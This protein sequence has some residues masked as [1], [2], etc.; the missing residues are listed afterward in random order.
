MKRLDYGRDRASGKLMTP[1]IFPCFPSLSLP[2]SLPLPLF[3]F[4]SACPSPGCLPPGLAVSQSGCRLPCS[5][6]SQDLDLTLELLIDAAARYER[7][8][9]GPAGMSAWEVGQSLTLSCG[10]A[11]LGL[12]NP[13]NQSRGLLDLEVFPNGFPSSFSRRLVRNRGLRWVSLR[14]AETVSSQSTGRVQVFVAGLVSTTVPDEAW[15]ALPQQQAE[16]Q[17]VQ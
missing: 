16:G 5:R 11:D 9:L 14:A 4:L 8:Q 7:R 10:N 13:G 2:L 12:V 15:H 1:L 6:A 3:L 17:L